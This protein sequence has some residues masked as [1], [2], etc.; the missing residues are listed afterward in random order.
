MWRAKQCGGVSTPRPE[1]FGNR[2]CVREEGGGRCRAEDKYVKGAPRRDSWGTWQGQ[3]GLG[4]KQQ[5]LSSVLCRLEGT[6]I[7]ALS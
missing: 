6:F 7:E 1:G 3:A 5:V 2:T 4:A